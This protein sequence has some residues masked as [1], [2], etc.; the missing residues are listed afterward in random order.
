VTAVDAEMVVGGQNDWV[1]E[2]F[3]HPDK[4]SIS[5]GHGNVGVLFD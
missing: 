4:A 1:I 3:G 2:N 5:K